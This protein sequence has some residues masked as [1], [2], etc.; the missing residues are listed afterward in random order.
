M[1]VIQSLENNGEHMNDRNIFLKLLSVL[2]AGAF[3]ASVIAPVVATPFSGATV[4]TSIVERQSGSDRSLAGHDLVQGFREKQSISRESAAFLRQNAEFRNFRSELAASLISSDMSGPDFGFHWNTLKAERSPDRSAWIED[5]SYRKKTPPA[6]GIVSSRVITGEGTVRFIDLEGGFFG[7]ITESG[8]HLL[9]ENLPEDC[10]VDGLQVTFAGMTRGP[11]ANVRMWGTPVYLV[12]VN[13]LESAGISAT[14]T[15]T[16]I[17]LEGGFFGIVT[18]AGEKYLPVNLPRDF[19]VDGLVVAFTARE[20]KDTA[21]IAMWGTP[22]FLESITLSEQQTPSLTGSWVLI[23][24]ADRAAL[25]SLVP[26]TAISATFGN[27]GRITGTAGCN[28]YFASFTAGDSLITVGD[29]GSTLMYCSLPEGSMEQ[30]ATYFTLLGNA[31]TWTTR[32]G[33]LVIRDAS[34][35]DILIFARGTPGTPDQEDVLVSYSRT[36]GFAGFSDHI[37]VY[38]DGSATVTRK[39]TVA[40]VTIPDETLRQFCFFLEQAHFP[41]LKDE[42]PAPQE[43]ADY[44]TY[45]VTYGGKTVVTEDTGIP[46]ELA[47]IFEI[48]NGIIEGSA[49]DDV[50]PPFTHP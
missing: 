9:P 40:S 27:D 34:G 45:S 15:V 11:A 50:I 42:Y 7:I 44:F 33:N 4:K 28:Q 25:R 19:Q 21:T 12:R 14:G 31:A 47:P 1:V 22:V 24:Y 32:D 3:L 2:I 10:Q 23:R 36:G 37:V 38:R 6:S 49:P 46:A 30:E 43:G 18:P 41:L 17:A 8:D 39:E 5:R 29:I 16:F 35:S 20:E 48:L 26:G 13:A